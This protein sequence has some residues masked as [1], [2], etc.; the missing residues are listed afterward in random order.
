[1]KG[2][3]TQE[4][5]TRN[6][7]T[8]HVSLSW[9]LCKGCWTYWISWHYVYNFMYNYSYSY[10]VTSN[11][12]DKDGNHYTNKWPY[13][14]TNIFIFKIYLKIIHAFNMNKII[15]TGINSCLHLQVPHVGFIIIIT[16]C[17]QWGNYANLGWNNKSWIK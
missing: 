16:H 5:G 15:F 6:K 17:G 3:L 8:V 14:E 10:M 1:M 4:Q 11:L 9:S 7:V 2:G 12:Q 13:S